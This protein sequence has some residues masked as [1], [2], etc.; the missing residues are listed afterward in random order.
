MKL[1]KG[2]FRN[3]TA[4]GMVMGGGSCLD[5]AVL[6]HNLFWFNIHGEEIGFG[7]L[8]VLDVE[9]IAAEID[10]DE[11]FIATATPKFYVQACDGVL[12]VDQL[13]KNCVVVIGRN[14]KIVLVYNN[15]TT[16]S[17]NNC[18]FE[19]M[20]PT[21]VKTF[22]V[23]KQKIAAMHAHNITSVTEIDRG[24]ELSK[25]DLNSAIALWLDCG[26]GS[27]FGDFLDML[28]A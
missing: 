9:R 18:E 21:E 19:P 17:M 22:I 23:E 1:T 5:S 3:E 2:F 8:T 25:R 12:A 6:F 4:F 28:T 20:R 11:L 27:T 26:K 13:V 16:W 15:M 10:E 24:V 7:D 14:L